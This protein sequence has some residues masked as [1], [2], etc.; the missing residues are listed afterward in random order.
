MAR[1]NVTKKQ[2]GG[3]EGSQELERSKGE[4]LKIKHDFLRARSR[5]DSF[6]HTQNRANHR[7]FLFSA[8]HRTTARLLNK[9]KF[10]IIERKLSV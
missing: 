2:F 8:D 3:L 7:H 1:G 4:I 9:W 10:R 5:V 6:Q